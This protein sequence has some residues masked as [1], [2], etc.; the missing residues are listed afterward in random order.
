MLVSILLAGCGVFM[1]YS[2]SFAKAATDL[3]N[4]LYF[5]KRQLIWVILGAIAMVLISRIPY[6]LLN[7]KIVAIGLAVITVL[8]LIMVFVPPFGYAIKG[9]YRWLDFK[10]AKFQPAE[11]AK[12]ITVIFMSYMAVRQRE[13]IKSLKRGVAYMVTAP[14]VFIGLIVAQSDL[15]SCIVIGTLML[16][17]LFVSGTRLIYLGGAVAIFIAGIVTAIKIEPFRV[18]RIFAFID[19]WPVA[20]STGYQ[21]IES[22]VAFGSGGFFGRG[23]G[24]GRQKLLYLPEPHTDFIL[25]T[26]GEEVG[27][28]GLWILFGLFFI[29]VYRA[30]QVALNMPERFG[31]LLGFGLAT[32]LALQIVINAMVVL[33]L[34]PN[35][36]L[37][38]PFLSYG[39]SSALL[40]FCTV[41]ILLSMSRHADGPN[42]KT[43]NKPTKMTALGEIAR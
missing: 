16:I 1:V 27:L 13:K 31:T 35:K 22:W 11:L 18:K 30:Y 17:M 37:A 20:K 40:N 33:G 7:S 21:I 10:W 29:L 32:L 28:F 19:P 3:G 41:G 5:L 24:Q 38:L 4:P 23:L 15:G 43:K 34:V 2:A 36:G 8:L 42:R 25:S 14:L 26:V 39:G 9:T 6:Q 12:L